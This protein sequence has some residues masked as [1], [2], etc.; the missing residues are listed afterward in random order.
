MNLQLADGSLE[1]PMGLLEN[2]LVKSCGIEFEHTFVVVDFG[3]ETN[4][5]VILGRPF[6]RQ[7]LMIQDWGYNYLYLRHE[8]VITR[9]NLKTHSYRDVTHSPVDEFDSGSSDESGRTLSEGR[10]DLWVCGASR[11]SICLDGSDWD[12]SVMDEAY[13]PVPFPEHL[14]DPQEFHDI[15]ATLD[16]SALP[17][18][19]QFCDP[20]GNDIIPIQND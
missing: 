2:V 4:Y 18:P 9:V 16:V 1:T 19:T 15:L 13:I 11:R 20:E 17:R 5:E 8:G 14:I 12:R 3:Q 10:A 6:M 7:F